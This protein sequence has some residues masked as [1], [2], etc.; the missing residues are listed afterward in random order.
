MAQMVRK[1]RREGDRTIRHDVPQ[2]L[3]RLGDWHNSG[4]PPLLGDLPS[5]PGV[6]IEFRSHSLAASPS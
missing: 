3:P 6:M 1:N 4:I 5:P 2:G